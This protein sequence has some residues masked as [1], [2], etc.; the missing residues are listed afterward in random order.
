MSS[1]E[2]FAILGISPQGATSKTIKKA[3][4]LKLKQTR[5]DEDPE[6]FMALRAAYDQAL[7]Y[8]AYQ[9]EYDIYPEA[10][11]E[12]AP[13]TEPA[14]RET[15]GDATQTPLPE[16]S[17]EPVIEP[18]EE[19]PSAEEAIEYWYDEELEY[20]LN[21]SP[22]GQLEEKTIRWIKGQS[23][24]SLDLKPSLK[25]LEALLTDPILTDR[26]IKDQYSLLWLEH[27]S[28]L[29]MSHP[30]DDIVDIQHFICPDWL[31]EQVILIIAA[32]IDI[33]KY[34]AQDE[35]EFLYHNCAHSFFDPVLIKHHI[36]KKPHPP[37]DLL[38]MRAQTFQRHHQDEHGSYYDKEK[39]QWVDMSPLSRAYSDI[40][41]LLQ[42]GVSDRY[43][44]DW[45]EVLDRDGLQPIDVYQQIDHYIRHLI[46]DN[47]GFNN[48]QDP[49]IPPWLTPD[50]MKCLNEYFGWY[51]HP[52]SNIAE[53]DAQIWLHKIFKQICPDL[54]APEGNEFNQKVN[55]RSF[56]FLGYQPLPL[57][58]RFDF[59]L[60]TYLTYRLIEALFKVI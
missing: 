46:L 50:L 24:D 2:A 34:G 40:Q 57:F 53:H 47:T 9:A 3:Y 56:D 31:T 42:Q 11:S 21:S 14:N 45:Q 30:Y 8:L 12:P 33:F 4:A 37:Y 41:K 22:Y 54:A 25:T 1:I 60:G 59:M 18:V 26:K 49:N 27:I 10:K 6:G 58:L 48:Q 5:P 23:N 20:H 16:A 36:L 7:K 39:R 51:H 15:E 29:T 13:K 52:L 19:W 44:E 55:R 28:D 38:E 17:P 32:N 43:L 35:E